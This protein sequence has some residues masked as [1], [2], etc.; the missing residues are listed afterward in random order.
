M[1]GA[2]I[3]YSLLRYTG[4]YWLAL[5]LA[6]LPSVPLARRANSA[7]Y[8]ASTGATRTPS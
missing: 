4:S 7:S 5:A 3:G 8:A 1:L 2:F 6:P